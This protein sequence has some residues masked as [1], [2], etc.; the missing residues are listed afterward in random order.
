MLGAKLPIAKPLKVSR[1]LHAGYIFEFEE[2][3]IVFDPIFEN[4]FS[5][6]CFAFPEVKFDLAEIKKLHFDA[7][8]ISHYHDDHC[9]FKS[10]SLLNRQTP[11]YVYCIFDEL[12]AMLSE[13]GFKNIHSLKLDKSILVGPFEI[14]PRK[15]LDDDVDCVIQIQVADYQILNMVDA[16]LDPDSLDLLAKLSPWD[17][18][19]W[20]F[21]TLREID[22]LCPRRAL[23]AQ[24]NLP[25]EWIE[26]LKILNPRIIV[27]SSCQFQFET[28]SWYNH[29]LFPITYA[30]FTNEIKGALAYTNIV[31]LNPSV[32]ISL[33]ANSFTP[34][35]PL[36][37][38]SPIGNQDVDFKFY[39]EQ[40]AL[41]SAEI[42]KNF[43][44]LELGQIERV[45]K[46]CQI[47]ILERFSSLDSPSD[48]FFKN[49][50]IWR[51]SIY[52]HLGSAHN[53]YYE[54]QNSKITKANSDELPLSWT[55]ELPISKLYG[56]L[57]EG[58]TLSSMYVQ[59]NSQTFSVEIEKELDGADL[60]EDP[61]LRCLF[62]GVFGAYQKCFLRTAR[63]LQ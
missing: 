59:I 48:S 52:D 29:F 13:L 19:L 11:I 9:S 25:P 17:L 63:A 15:A 12:F 41:P 1:I 10:L 6:N 28:W 47:E 18:V 14:I 30:Q 24:T 35:S 34:A 39:P 2:T 36:N 31:M 62:N 8:F 22:V 43:S 32:T 58:E 46:Y 49:K 61:L 23:P 5:K 7:I 54:I 38:I 42:A 50:R 3:K 56:A 20:P 57:E 55:T 27:P 26:Q 53:F 37:W 44:A 51:L 16:W 4:P 60:L 33:I 40:K 45:F 21:Q